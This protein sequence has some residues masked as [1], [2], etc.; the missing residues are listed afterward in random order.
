MGKYSLQVPGRNLGQKQ[1]NSGS[2]EIEQEA[3][4]RDLDP[5]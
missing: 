5:S 3:K 2:L 1:A 4:W